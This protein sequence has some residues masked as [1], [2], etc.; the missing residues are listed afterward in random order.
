VEDWASSKEEA[1]RSPSSRVSSHRFIIPPL[2]RG[3]SHLLAVFRRYTFHLSE[4]MAV[5]GGSRAGFHVTC[6][7]DHH[8]RFLVPSKLVGFSV[9]E[10]KRIITKH[11]DVYFH[12][13]RDGGAN[14][15]KE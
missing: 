2:T 6:I 12:L 10:L 5:L 13:W 9:C 11:F 1:S 7:R 3:A 15:F 8:F 14:W 4:A